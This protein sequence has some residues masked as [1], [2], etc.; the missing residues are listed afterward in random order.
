MTPELTIGPYFVEEKLNRSDLRGDRDGVQLALTMHVF[1]Y[2]KD[3]AA[4]ADAQIDLWHCDALG[5]YSDVQ[6][7]GT[8]GQTWLRGFQKTDT[9][10]VATFTTIFPGYYQGRTTHI[11][12]RV[13]VNDLD[14]TTQ[15][16][17]T[18]DQTA[19]VNGVA[20]YTNN[21]TNGTRLKNTDD[22]IYR[23][24]GADVL[25]VTL[26]GTTDAGYTGELSLGISAG[27][28]TASSDDSVDAAFLGAGVV[29]GSGGRRRVRIRLTP[30]ERVAVAATVTRRG[31][32]L[33]RLFGE[34]GAGSQTVFVRIPKSIKAGPAKLRVTLTDEANNTRTIKRA[35]HIPRKRKT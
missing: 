6:Q 11:H 31:R 21:N 16:F 24:G 34:L 1:D 15:I 2:D 23:Q 18:E 10:G 5:K 14:F 32:R 35:V 30:A 26:S 17:F 9:A 19:T 25:L 12:V 27:T 29:R 3:C 33:A 28:P 13:R 22:G 20:P 8:T 7:N 4:V